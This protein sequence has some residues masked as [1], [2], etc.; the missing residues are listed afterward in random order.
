MGLDLVEVKGGD[1]GMDIRDLD[2]QLTR[3]IESQMPINVIVNLSA[4]S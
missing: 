3:L 1:Q 2:Y 4:G